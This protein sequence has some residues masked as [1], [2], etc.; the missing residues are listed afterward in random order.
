MARVNRASHSFSLPATHTLKI[1]PA[2]PAFTFQ[3]QFLAAFWHVLVSRAAEGRRLSWPE[4]L[5][6]YT[7]V[8]CRSKSSK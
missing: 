4:L 2:M 6:T 7:E 1:E 3:P 5:V 8:V